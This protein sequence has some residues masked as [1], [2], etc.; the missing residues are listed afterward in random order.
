MRRLPL[1]HA[2]GATLEDH[3]LGVAEDDVFRVE[4]HRLD[5]LDAGDSSRPRAV[6]DELRRLEVTAGQSQ[7]V[8]EAGSGDDRRAV[9]VV[10]EHRD[11]HDLAQLLLDDETVR[12]LDVLEID[13]AE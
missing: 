9:L 7:R 13:A 6:A 11:V 4:A 3:A 1:V 2:L 10:V 8:D 5:E 12:R